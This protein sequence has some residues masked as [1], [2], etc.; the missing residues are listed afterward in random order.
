MGVERWRAETLAVLLSRYAI[1]PDY[2]QLTPAH[3]EYMYGKP[4][5]DRLERYAHVFA[6]PIREHR[7]LLSAPPYQIGLEGFRLSSLDRF[8]LISK[9]EPHVWYSPN[10]RLLAWSA[11]D[12]IHFTLNENEHCRDAYQNVRGH[13]LELYLKKLLETRAPTLT[14]IPEE[15][16]RTGHGEG[17]GP[18]LIIIDHGPPPIVLGI[19]VKFRR[20]LPRTRFELSDDDLRTNYEDL[21]KAIKALPNKL[22]KVFEL[23]GGYKKFDAELERA[24]DYPRWNIGLAGEAP[25]M[26]GELTLALSRN[27]SSFPLFGFQEPWAVMTVEC[28]ERFV[29]V[30]VQH[31]RSVAKV[32]TE[33]QEDCAD[34]ELS[35][36]MADSFKNIK[37]NEEQ[38]Y[39]ASFLAA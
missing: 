9:D 15:K 30:V 2:F 8:P 36:S 13:L 11:H 35:G 3:F 5:I 34:L 21:W 32:I 20:M 27:N 19:E 4:A 10:V 23:A 31:N 16:W 26:F 22:V 6:R 33:Y 14:V 24:R 7:M 28:F 1:Q 29:E 37:L 25:F 18:D 39:A 12:V 38:S 17:K